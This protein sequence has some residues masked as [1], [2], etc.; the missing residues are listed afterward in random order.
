MAP[1]WR[2][3]SSG[4]KVCS[5]CGGTE[6]VRRGRCGNCRQAPPAGQATAGGDAG[7]PR[8]PPAP[9]EPV[10]E[11][12]TIEPAHNRPWVHRGGG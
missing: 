3:R 6:D 1:W 5:S 9:R 7:R 4:P 12:P 11:S 10:P 2:G 8:N